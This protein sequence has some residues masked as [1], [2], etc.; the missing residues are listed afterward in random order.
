MKEIN[1]NQE[2]LKRNML[3]LIELRHIL[4]KTQIFFEQVRINCYISQGIVSLWYLLGC[5][6]YLH[7]STYILV[8]SFV[9]FTIYIVVFTL[10]IMCYYYCT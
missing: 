6:Y 7:C 9:V 1:T 5:I 2:T 8:F 3:D 10:L 4:L